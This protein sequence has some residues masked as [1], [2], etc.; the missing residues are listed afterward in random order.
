[1][2]SFLNK[3]DAS[4]A[5][6]RPLW[7]WF[8]QVALVVLG[9]HQAAD[10][11]DDALGRG[12]GQIPIGWEDP[13]T[14]FVIGRWVGVVLEMLI[15]LWAVRTLFRTT[16]NDL[17]QWK[18]WRDRWSV[19]NLMAPLF[20][21]PV[22]LAGSWS[23]AMALEDA[24]P[25]HPASTGVAWT[26]AGLVALRLGLTAVYTLL[27][28]PPPPKRRIEGWFWVLPLSVVAGYAV[29]YGLPI[30]GWR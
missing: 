5:V 7:L 22:S 17:K 8:G 29:W 24:L 16:D 26:V 25:V 21:L 18:D 28:A 27:H 3:L 20:W 19:H 2:L 12:V 30:W 14:A 4:V 1:M 10:R 11:M 6:T 13:Q 15:T 9:T 23:I